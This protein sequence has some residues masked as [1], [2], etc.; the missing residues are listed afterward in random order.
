MSVTLTVNV[1]AAGRRKPL[2]SD[3]SV[4]F[5]PDL[6]PDG[7][8]ITLRD[9]IERVVRE[10]V[11]AFKKRQAQRRLLH[12]LTAKQ[13]D[14]GLAQGKVTSGGS[15][16]DQTVDEDE[17]VEVALQAF[18]DGIFL[19]V[20]DEEQQKELDREVFVRPDSCLTF[21]RLVLLA[22]G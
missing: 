16:L 22:G 8:R 17:A 11:R 5:P 12:V 10:E 13:I 20:V 18:S 7:G 3:W 14:E 6:S 15:E 1:K 21:L 19:V 9:L 2:L 4:P